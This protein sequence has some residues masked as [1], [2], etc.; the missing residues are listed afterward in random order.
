MTPPDR[1]QTE[2][3]LNAV[4]SLTGPELDKAMDDVVGAQM[5]GAFSALARAM[6]PGISDDDRAKRVH[7]M[8]LAYLM[9]R[10]IS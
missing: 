2:A 9:H 4:Q 8:V 3:A 10:E 6:E 1:K 5:L 7:L